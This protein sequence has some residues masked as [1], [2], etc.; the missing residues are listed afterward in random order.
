MSIRPRH[1]FAT[2]NWKSHIKRKLNVYSVLTNVAK[3]RIRN[4]WNRME[5]ER[6]YYFWL[7]K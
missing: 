4:A 6:D 2:F 5:I 7:N 3:W 1:S